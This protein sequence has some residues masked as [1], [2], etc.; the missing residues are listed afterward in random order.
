MDELDGG[1]AEFGGVVVAALDNLSA[2]E[3]PVGEAVDDE[4]DGAKYYEG[5]KTSVGEESTFGT[6]DSSES[7]LTC[8]PIA[9]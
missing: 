2:G 7:L 6:T 5:D 3:T 9:C 1:G 8:C 4:A